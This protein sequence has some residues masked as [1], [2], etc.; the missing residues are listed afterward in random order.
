MK[1]PTSYKVPIF[2]REAPP[3][4]APPAVSDTVQKLWNFVWRPKLVKREHN[5][6]EAKLPLIFQLTFI[7]LVLQTLLF[8]VLALVY[9]EIGYEYLGTSLARAY[10]TDLPFAP[11]LL[12]VVIIAPLTEEIIF[13]LPLIYT[14]SF[15]L[16]AIF[17]LLMSYG[18]Y[19]AQAFH[20]SWFH[21]AAVAS[22]LALLSLWLLTSNKLQTKVY[23]FWK[24]HFGLVFYTSAALFAL[25]HLLNYKEL[26]L[27]LAMLLL[28][29]LPKLLGGI[30]LGYTRLRLGLGW[31]IG[32][33]IFN[34][35]VALLLL[36]GYLTEA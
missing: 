13:R 36:Y 34:N 28:L 16:V 8:V 14:R 30:F 17:A 2:Y 33:H 22:A 25:L 19:I 5:V 6:L 32:F 15:V 1:T 31:A 3:F 27:P 10:D 35:L 11:L 23:L 18:P 26:D 4:N 21:Y 12:S 7:H 24:R 29:A 20:A 9:D